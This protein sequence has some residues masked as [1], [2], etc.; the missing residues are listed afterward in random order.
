MK[1]R[2]LILI[3]LF[4]FLIPLQIRAALT[5][6]EINCQ[7]LE[8]E[9]KILEIQERI[10]VLKEDNSTFYFKSKLE[11]GDKREEVKELQIFLNKKLEDKI[12]K[13]GP[14]SPGNETYY[15]GELTRRAVIRFQEKYS[16]E[17]L[18]P[19]GFK[20][21]TGIVGATTRMKLNRLLHQNEIEE[22]SFS[23]SNKNPEQGDTIVL[24]I[25]DSKS[26]E[27]I[28]V[29]FNNKEYNFNQLGSSDEKLVFLPIGANFNPGFYSLVIYSRDRGYCFN[30][31]IV[32]NRY[33]PQTVL[34]VTPELEEKGYNPEMIQENVGKENKL[35]FEEVLSKEPGKFIFKDS[36]TK[37]LDKIKNVGAYGNLRISG[38][39][40]LR[41]LGVDLEADENTP[42][43]SIN[44]GIVRFTKE[45]KDYGN[46]MVIDHGGGVRSLYLHLDEFKAKEGDKVSK[47]EEIALSGNTGYSIAPH[48]HLSINIYGTSVDPLKFLSIDF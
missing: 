29:K 38:N 1:K 12:A 20:R 15:F 8:I 41:H 13:I 24:K 33:F 11:K 5:I 46:T 27:D 42:V 47:G 10:K 16:E 44:D 25:K 35:L 45:I 22:D 7:I 48:L 40:K 18:D 4:L 9:T 6:E 3:I 21:G 30:Y 19:W 39:V 37:P 34:E 2:F 32:K 36:F 14:G 43:Y 23:I 28:K 17:I 26:E 31:I